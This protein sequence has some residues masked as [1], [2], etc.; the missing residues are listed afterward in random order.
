V[1]DRSLTLLAASGDEDAFREIVERYRRYIY[2]IAWKILLHEEDALD[3][4]AEVMAILAE[5]IGSWNGSGTF[6]AWLATITAR[7]AISLSRRA[8]RKHETPTNP[9][10]LDEVGFS[11]NGQE[12]FKSPR[13][14]LALK[15]QR[16]LV[17]EA[18][19]ALTPQQ[20]AIF[21]LRWKESLQPREIAERLDLKPSQVR[22]QLHRAIGRI[23]E[24]LPEGAV[25]G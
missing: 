1:D 14:E 7:E 25:E 11:V 13:A 5:H 17:T 3:I 6:K 4:T 12:A 10:T 9:A 24:A 20:R 2:T 8:Q 22:V 16:K 15:E 21:W 23:R 19:I 18:M